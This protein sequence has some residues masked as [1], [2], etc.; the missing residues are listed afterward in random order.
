M[1]IF[2][3][4]TQVGRDAPRIPLI[5][6]LRGKNRPITLSKK[7]KKIR[8]DKVQRTVSLRSD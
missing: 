2:R 6:A 3:Y 5:I 4:S 7:L 8:I 1:N